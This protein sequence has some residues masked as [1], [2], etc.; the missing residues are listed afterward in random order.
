[1]NLKLHKVLFVTCMPLEMP[2][3]ASSYF[4][5]VLL[6]EY[7]DRFVWYSLYH[8]SAE[9]WNP[10]HIP[11]QSARPPQRPARWKGLKYLIRYYP[12]AWYQGW[13]AAQFGKKNHAQV[14]LAD[15]AFEAV[16]A[17]RIA[18]KLLKVPL[19]VSI[20]DDPIN[21][22]RVKNLPRC[23]M[24]MYERSFQRT[25]QTAEK[26]AVISDYMGEIYQERYGV[27]TTR[28]YIGVEKE[29]ILPVREFDVGK[30]VFVIGSVGS[31]NS[32][33][34]WNLLLQA[35]QQFNE[36][37][38]GAKLK[39]LHIGKLP[40]G[41]QMT[42][43]VEVTGWVPENRFVHHLSRIDAGFLNWSFLPE[44]DMTGRTSFPLK[45]HSFLQA[46]VPFIGLGPLNSS[47]VRLISDYDCGVVCTEQDVNELLSQIKALFLDERLY[48]VFQ[49]NLKSAADDFSRDDFFERFREFIG[50]EV[51]YLKHS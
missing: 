32:A 19:L 38:D 16:I 21:R 12:W 39:I 17:G 4:M 48:A 37:G 22:L 23:C 2:K 3:S 51:A 35:V 50:F 5:S 29:N 31:V 42:D 14:V 49:K 46:Q 25:L 34:N 26:C 10:Y 11:Y 18:A 28:L 9:T 44:H 40:A 27:K 43:D 33:E 24:N 20:H 13:K 7:P 6:D 8:H 45:V 15:L 30:D 41:L 36:K 1:M 47:I